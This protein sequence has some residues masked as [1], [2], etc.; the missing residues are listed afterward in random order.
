MWRWRSFTSASETVHTFSQWPT[1]FQSLLHPGVSVDQPSP[2]DAPMYQSWWDLEGCQGPVSAR[3]FSE[4][5]D[6]NAFLVDSKIL[7]PAAQVGSEKGN[8][9]ISCRRWWLKPAKGLMQTELCEVRATVFPVKLKHRPEMDIVSAQVLSLSLSEKREQWTIMVK[10]KML[11]SGLFTVWTS[12]HL[13]NSTSLSLEKRF[14]G[15]LIFYSPSKLQ[16]DEEAGR[17]REALGKTSLFPKYCRDLPR[18]DLLAG[19]V[20]WWFRIW[21]GGLWINE[22][23]CFWSQQ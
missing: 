12:S 19:S 22:Y 16:D 15:Q 8:E 4:I 23:A 11:H 9:Y 21:F 13:W 7:L 2:P 20:L 6:F 10:K 17:T 14:M 5:F 3:Y 18:M 1:I